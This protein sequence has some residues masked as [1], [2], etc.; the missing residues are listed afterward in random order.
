MNWKDVVAPNP[1]QNLRFE[2]LANGQ[3]GLLW[4]I[5]QTASD[6]DSAKRYV[7]YRFDYSNIQPGDLENSANILNVE[8]SRES[9]P[10]EPPSPTGPFY[11]VVTSLDRNYN[12]SAMSNILQVNPSPIPVLALPLN[13]AINIEDTVTLKWNY[14]ALASSY[15][16]QISKIPTFDSLIVFDQK[17]LTDTFKV[18]TGLEGQQQYYW[19]VNSTNAGGTSSFSNVFSF[20]T[21][22]PTTPILSYPV[23]NT[24][25]I[26][27]DTV[28]YWNPSQAVVSYDLMLAR[29]ADFATNTIVVNAQGITDT[30]II[31]AGMNVNTFHF[32]KVRANNAFGKSNWS[33]VWRFKTVNPLGIDDEDLMPSEYVLEQNY[34]N[35]FNPST[36]FRF[37]IAEAGLT[38]LKIYNLLGQEVAVVLDEF[39]NPG[40]YDFR[41]DAT[42]LSSGIYFYR[43]RVNDFSASKKMIL[44]R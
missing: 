19:R 40:T 20:T 24:G 4:D 33:P 32:W 28:L 26:P 15:T 12:E 9:I 8:G 27:V 11:F 21:G 39:M 3:G 35:P 42:G 6:G 13:N 43:I 31:V 41:F 2:R 1:P 10:G 38:T 23:N 30:S 17:N 36:N 25:N 18:I 5:P 22:F 16:L 7:V 37:K 44:V 14:P 29:S 34:P